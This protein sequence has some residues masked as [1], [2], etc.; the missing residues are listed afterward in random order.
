MLV[1]RFRSFYI[2][3]ALTDNLINLSIVCTAVTIVLKVF[4]I[5]CT[6]VSI[7]YTAVSIAFTVGLGVTVVQVI[8]ASRPHHVPDTTSGSSATSLAS[9]AR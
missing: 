8:T 5:V 7:V 4:T 6:T 2:V 3:V 1:H 9:C